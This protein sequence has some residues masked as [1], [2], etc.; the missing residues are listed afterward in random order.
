MPYQKC[1]AVLPKLL[2]LAEVLVTFALGLLSHDPSGRE[3]K[4]RFQCALI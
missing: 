2:T 3:F 4:E 1:K